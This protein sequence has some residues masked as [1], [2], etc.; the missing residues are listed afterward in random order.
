MMRKEE[1]KEATPFETFC[2]TC[3]ITQ[4][5]FFIFFHTN[6]FDLTISSKFLFPFWCCCMIVTTR[7]HSPDSLVHFPSYLWMMKD[8]KERMKVIHTGFGITSLGFHP[9]ML[10]HQSFS[11]L[12]CSTREHVCFGKHADLYTRVCCAGEWEDAWL[13][14]REIKSEIPEEPSGTFR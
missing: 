1:I 14:D 3:C 6:S 8:K 13:T 5:L 7:N 11:F 10:M 9:Q 2:L 4:E 12:P